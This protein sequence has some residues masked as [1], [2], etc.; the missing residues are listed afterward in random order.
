MGRGERRGGR[1]GE[2]RGGRAG[3]WWGGRAGERRGESRGASRGFSVPPLSSEMWRRV[4]AFLPSRA[5][6]SSSSGLSGV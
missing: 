2:R 5:V 6:V 4:S 3:E 1:A